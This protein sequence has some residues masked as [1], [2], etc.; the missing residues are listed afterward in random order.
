MILE[1]IFQ[2]KKQFAEYVLMNLEKEAKHLKWSAAAKEL[3]HL[4]TRIV[5]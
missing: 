4:L 3:L 5:Y 2:R 1:K